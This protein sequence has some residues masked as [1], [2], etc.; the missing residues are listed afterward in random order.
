M[1]HVSNIMVYIHIS[2]RNDEYKKKQGSICPV[3]FCVFE[4]VL[5]NDEFC[6][7][8]LPFW[9]VKRSPIHTWC[10]STQVKGNFIVSSLQPFH[11]LFE[12]ICPEDRKF[13]VDSCLSQPKI[14]IMW[15]CWLAGFGYK[16][17]DSKAIVVLLAN[18]EVQDTT[19]MNFD[20]KDDTAPQGT[21]AW[22][23]I[24]PEEAPQLTTTNWSLVR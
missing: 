19:D 12:S 9:C 1:T 23:A 8:K 17:T 15:V 7:L 3:L 16:S 20:L 14:R 22:T 24:L 10:I 11:F 21:D 13:R 2:N 6:V 18:A 5:L 4:V